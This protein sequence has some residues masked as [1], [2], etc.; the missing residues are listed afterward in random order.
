MFD[1]RAHFPISETHPKMTSKKMTNSCEDCV[2]RDTTEWRV[3]N[4]GE[5]ESIDKCK[6]VI[7]CE[8]GE[9]LFSQG[10]PGTGIFCIQSGLIGLRRVD[11]N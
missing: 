9:T 1:N 3:L 4:D 5:L 7:H 2:T 6:R 10:D 11:V 8:P